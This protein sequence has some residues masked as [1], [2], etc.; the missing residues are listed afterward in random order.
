[1]RMSS[2]ELVLWKSGFFKINATMVTTWALML[3]LALGS[4]LITRNLTTELSVPKWQ[5]LLEIIVTSMK[6]QIQEVGSNNQRSISGFS[7]TLFLFIGAASLC[8][9]IPGYE[10]PTGSLS[11]TIALALCVFFAVRFSGFRRREWAAT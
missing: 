2:D 8:I 3:V 5:N 6:T 9:I 10:P 4:K 7:G 1:M 11:T